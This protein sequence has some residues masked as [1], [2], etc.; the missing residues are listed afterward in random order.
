MP[1]SIENYY[2]YYVSNDELCQVRP[3]KPLE[4]RC[5]VRSCNSAILREESN[6]LERTQGARA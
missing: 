6:R 2:S 3:W 1:L 5:G 4:R